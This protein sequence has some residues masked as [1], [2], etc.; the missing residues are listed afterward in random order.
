MQWLFNF[1]KS[2]WNF[3]CNL[4]NSNDPDDFDN[5]FPNNFPEDDVR[6]TVEDYINTDLD[7]VIEN[8]LIEESI[9]FIPQQGNP[10][11]VDDYS[12]FIGAWAETQR[13]WRNWEMYE[14][15]FRHPLIPDYR[16]IAS[17]YSRFLGDIG[18]H[19]EGVN[20][21]EN[22]DV[23]PYRW[24]W[25]RVDQIVAEYPD[26]PIVGFYDITWVTI[27]IGFL[28]VFLATTREN[29]I[30]LQRAINQNGSF[31]EFGLAAWNIMRG[32]TNVR[33]E[34]VE[35]RR[36]G[37]WDVLIMSWQET[38]Q[39][40]QN[41]LHRNFHLV[42]YLTFFA[43]WLLLLLVVFRINSNAG[44]TNETDVFFQISDWIEGNPELLRR[45]QPEL[46]QNPRLR[47]ICLMLQD[48]MVAQ[49]V[50]GTEIDWPVRV[51]GERLDNNEYQRIQGIFNYQE[52]RDFWRHWTENHIRIRGGEDQILVEH[53]NE[54]NTTWWLI[55]AIGIIGGGCF[56]LLQHSTQ[57]G[58][59][60]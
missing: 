22:A 50:R 41:Y 55:G 29:R 60:N 19:P 35:N 5:L 54:S 42:S 4:F 16:F 49:G 28:T 20:F 11:N 9:R 8:S 56:Y 34:L 26:A 38:F 30:E 58:I 7:P 18:V 2:V 44:I 21:N 25:K 52:A 59:L 45:Q 36:A 17:A 15:A 39:I 48:F 33:P 51:L 12:M 27:G 37:L 32:E 3:I 47:G 40:F 43:P 24:F 53:A 1:F 57:V 10:L 13:F 14:F 23:G 6:N 46:V 31:R